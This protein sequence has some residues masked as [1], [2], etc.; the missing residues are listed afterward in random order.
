ME[1]GIQW[2]TIEGSDKVLLKYMFA[3]LL[4]K[5][6]ELLVEW[7][8]SE[9]GEQGSGFGTSLLLELGL[10]I[11]F[12]IFSKILFSRFS[13]S[14]IFLSTFLSFN[15]SSLSSE[16][17]KVLKFWRFSMVSSFFLMTLL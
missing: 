5:R 13:M 4:L 9:R 1:G 17:F 7:V 11:G 16:F 2:V 14:L 15:F 12:F 3:G 8:S 10:Q 6:L